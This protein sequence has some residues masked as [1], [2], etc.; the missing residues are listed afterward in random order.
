MVL[1]ITPAT[2]QILEQ[3]LQNN[4]TDGVWNAYNRAAW[5]NQDDVLFEVGGN[6]VGN[7]VSS[8]GSVAVQ[9]ITFSDIL[10]NID[11]SKDIDLMKV[12]IEGAEEAFFENVRVNDLERIKR[13]VIEFH[14]EYC[15]VQNLMGLLKKR[16]DN[17]KLISGRID[18]K[19][20]YECF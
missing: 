11:L 7:K 13:M 6:S 18:D 17:V 1:P 3:N 9:G 16:Y 15:D 4:I 19:P 5:K 14:P 8:T 20:L 12:D 2:Y 10:K